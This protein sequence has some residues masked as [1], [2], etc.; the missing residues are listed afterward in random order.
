MK[1]IYLKKKC[2]NSICFCI[3]FEYHIYFND[4]D[5]INKN[6]KLFQYNYIIV[7]YEKLFLFVLIIIEM[8]ILFLHNII[9]PRIIKLF[10]YP[11]FLDPIYFHLFR[12]L[13]N[14]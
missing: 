5:N 2:N 3:I 10:F 1:F 11:I 14:I 13:Q 4:Y 7:I 8:R 9:R 12:L 6:I